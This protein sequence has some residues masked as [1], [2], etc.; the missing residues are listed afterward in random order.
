MRV[1]TFS[2]SFGS[3]G[4]VIAVG[5]AEALGWK[6]INRLIPAEVASKLSIPLELALAKDEA[7]ES[8]LG[9]ILAR[10]SVQVPAE[11]TGNLP[12]EAFVDD[13]EFRSQSDDYIR[14]VAA[15][16]NCVIVG[17][18]SAIVL[19]NHDPALHVRIDGDPERRIL[20][21]A[22]ALKISKEESASRLRETDNA[23]RSYVKHFYGRDWTDPRLY[24]VMLDST[25][26]TL[27]TCV[28]IVV[29]AA[30]NRFDSV[31]Q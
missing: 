10:L 7:S 11:A 22:G 9:R 18:A 17:R 20:N 30:S 2:S 24:H 5:V 13:R 6:L 1:I 14:R 4:S 23:R 12:P 8:R 28:Q 15:A 25:V 31:E 27:S 26:L 19:A 29:R 3:G 16:S 21:G